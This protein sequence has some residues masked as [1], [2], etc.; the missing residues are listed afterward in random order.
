MARRMI[1]LVASLILALSVSAPAAFGWANGADLDGDGLGDN[2]Y[3]THDWL[4]DNAITLAGPEGA[5][6]AEQKQTALFA[7][8]DPD[9]Q[10]T[11][12]SELHLFRDEG[13][14]RGA[15]T[16][17]ANA[18]AE[19]VEAYRVGDM[20]EAARCVGVLSHYYGDISQPF[21]TEYDALPY[22]TYHKNYEIMVDEVTGKP[23]ENYA[24][25]APASYSY[26]PVTDIRAKAVSSAYY[27]RSKFP[28]LLGGLKLSSK[29]TQ[30][31]VNSVSKQVLTRASYDLADI[32]RTIPTSAGVAQ[33]PATIKATM[34]KYYPAQNSKVCV[35][36][37]CLD[38]AGKPIEAAAV[39]IT[40][41]LKA[42]PKTYRAYTDAKGLAYAW[43]TIDAMPLMSKASVLV[44]SE[45]GSSVSSEMTSVS[46]A[47]TWFMPTP[48]LKD[49]SG[50]IKTDM[51]NHY[52]KRYSSVTAST[53]IRDRA[54]K[55][56]VG[57][58]VTF[59]WKYKTVT[60]TY[61]VVTNS[62]GVAKVTCNIG[63]ATRGYRVYVK[64]QTMSGGI[65]R[66]STSTFIPK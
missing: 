60:K 49:G 30:T 23:G 61:K 34:Y 11:V 35:Y 5:W 7:T 52:P 6:I 66:S 37:T 22:E 39:D 50:G 18:Y 58:P 28:S 13:I 40:V 38:A 42:G 41:P 32:I 26:K 33:A 56:V 64:A 53:V 29:I 62:S 44:E 15:P 21:H 51:S 27:S 8:D 46:S 1:I 48:I 10:R 59:S 31:T 12:Q 20:A 3:G 43:V 24:W 2:G 25:I 65:S 9:T 14:G 17:I 57:L 19:A 47:T 4:L 54:G 55:A 16:A 36:A 63:G 45:S